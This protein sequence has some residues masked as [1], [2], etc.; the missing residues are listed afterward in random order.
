[1][2]LTDAEQAIVIAGRRDDWPGGPRTLTPRRATREP[3]GTLWFGA[4][5]DGSGDQV[6]FR[7]DEESIGRLPDKTPDTRG[8]HLID[9]LLV[10]QE[11]RPSTQ[12]GAQPIRRSCLRHRDTW[13]ER[14]R[15]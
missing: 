3:N 7:I 13:V 14:L 6:W 4:E 8:R 2:D 15:W 9:A 10:H 1:M 11:E 5:L 12:I